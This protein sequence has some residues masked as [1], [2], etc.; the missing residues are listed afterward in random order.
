MAIRCTGMH[1]VGNVLTL[2]YADDEEPIFTCQQE[3]EVDDYTRGADGGKTPFA[4][5]RPAQWRAVCKDIVTLKR[6]TKADQE[7]TFACIMA[8]ASDAAKGIF[9]DE[10]RKEIMREV[11]AQ[12]K[13]SRKSAAELDAISAEAFDRF[14]ERIS[15]LEARTLDQLA[16]MVY[17]R[18]TLDQFAE[19][20]SA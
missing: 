10:A 14:R 1:A 20:V 3:F 6:A 16:D 4:S 7:S 19:A 12:Y 9:M 2:A 11:K 8:F 15:R 5:I 18:F 13:S 17:P